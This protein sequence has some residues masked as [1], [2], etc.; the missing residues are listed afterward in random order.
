VVNLDEGVF[1]RRKKGTD[2]VEDPPEGLF[3]E[4]VI[5]LTHRIASDFHKATRGSDS[6]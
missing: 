6:G 4:N 5:V 3:E 1:T 2:L